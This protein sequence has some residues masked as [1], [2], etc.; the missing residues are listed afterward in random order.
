M[1]LRTLRRSPTSLADRL[2]LAGCLVFVTMIVQGCSTVRDAQIDRMIANA[3]SPAD[4][5]AIAAAY[6]QESERNKEEAATH[7]KI[8]QSY[9]R[10]PRWKFDYSKICRDMAERYAGLAKEDA[11]LAEEHRRMAEKMQAGTEPSSP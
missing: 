9:D 3:K 8:A 2:A 5:E 7:W 10:R 1:K 11:D 6:Q 4:H